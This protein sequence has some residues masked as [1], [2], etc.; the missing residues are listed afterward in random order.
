MRATSHA[1]SPSA[2]WTAQRE[3]RGGRPLS[4]IHSKDPAVGPSSQRRRIL[5]V[6][7]NERDMQAV[8]AAFRARGLTVE[9]ALG[10]RRALERLAEPGSPIDTLL[11]TVVME[12]M[13]AF[14]VMDELERLGGFPGRLVLI[15]AKPDDM[16][17]AAALYAESV[18]YDYLGTEYK[19]LRVERLVE[20]VGG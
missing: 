8:A 1:Y 10:G 6:D 18:G 4:T 2:N 9:T 20:L 11:L 12:G 15:A 7:D 5:V 14:E 3:P 16:P 19:P 17:R 13:D